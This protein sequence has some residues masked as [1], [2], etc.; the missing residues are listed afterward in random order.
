M[1]GE[2]TG[3]TR[4][5]AGDRLSAWLSGDL[6]DRDAGLVRAH[7]EGCRACGEVVAGLRA[8][9][10]S[11]RELARPDPPPTLW[12]TIAGALEAEAERQ[13][14]RWSWP[15]WLF[16]AFAGASLAACVAWLL[17]GRADFAGHG[18]VASDGVSP[19]RP[20]ADNQPGGDPLL[21]EA[22]QELDR[23]AD[24]YANAARRLRTILDREQALWAP[25]RRARVA[26]RLARL[27][28]AIVHSRALADLDPG[29]S[30]GAE[31]LFS[32]YQNQIDFLAEA[33]HRGSPG[34]DEGWR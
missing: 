1:T 21:A 34:P 8:Q 6:G 5:L 17:F 11:L 16:G 13:G 33:V 28:E 31:M 20:A 24:S 9:A 25:E 30:A 10:E 3:V 18:R 27:D 29:D 15:S 32:A 23:A 19:G 26:E 2:A 4:H 14:R 22:E 12:P 7:L